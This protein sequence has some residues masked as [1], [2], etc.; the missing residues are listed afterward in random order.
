MAVGYKK[1]TVN[2]F[3]KRIYHKR[4]LPLTVV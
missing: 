4:H 3:G 2:G 1:T